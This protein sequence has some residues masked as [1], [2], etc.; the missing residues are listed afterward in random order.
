MV[1]RT[2]GHGPNNFALE[3]FIDELASAGGQDPYQ[4]RRKLLADQPVALAVLDRAA[5]LANWGK[6]EPGRFLGLAFADGFGSYLCQVV[7]LSLNDGAV[8]IHKVISVCDPG[9]VFDRVNSMSMIE[10]GVHWGLSAA[11]YSAISFTQGHVR[12]TNFHSYRV[13]T[14][15]DTP[16]LVT[17]FLE[18]RE[19]LGGLGEIGPVCIPAALCNALFAATGVRH[20]RL[21]LS[22]ARVFTT[23]GKIFG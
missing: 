13:V 10:G 6:P 8:K 3:S 1:L 20:R 15:P 9:R 22:K 19:T 14:L 2:T 12:E 11:L 16:E 17:D 4:Y 5:A 18:N 23:Y 21:P 7:E